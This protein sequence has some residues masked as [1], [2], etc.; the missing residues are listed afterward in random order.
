MRIVII[1]G[2][3][4][5]ALSV[6]EA[7]PSQSQVLVIGRK[8]GLEGD[9]ALSLEYQTIKKMG[10]SFKSITTGRLQRK[11]TKH[12]IFSLIKL[13]IGFFQ[14]L[15]ILKEF[16]PNVVLSFG[17]YVSIPVV[18]AS[19]F[20]RIP[21]VVHEQT[22]EAGLSN[23]FASLFAKKICIS[24]DSSKKFFPKSKIVLTGNP[25]RKFTISNIKFPI[26]NFKFQIDEKDKNLP[27]IY[28]TGGSSGSHAIN[29]LIEEII[30][31]LL[32]KNVVFHQTG[33]AQEFQDFS[34]LEDLRRS[35]AE[36]LERR[37][38]LTKFVEPSEVGP[39]IEKADIL[40]S[41]SGMNTVSELIQFQKPAL[42]I[43]LPYSQNKEQVKNAFFLKYLGLAEVADQNK[44]TAN[45][46]FD[47]LEIMLRNL[48]KYKNNSA[49]GLIKKD[50][51][52]KIVEVLGYSAE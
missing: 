9:K 10:I 21:I 14:A 34:R 46:L 11:F 31:K 16:K 17:G 1:G 19:F 48:D 4:S 28:I 41:R 3:F 7:L 47:L 22:L 5:P 32:E 2:H 26:S 40:I 23:K 44:L 49:K 36:K 38:F 35:F 24:W 43:P 52:K 45:D 25:I 42:L 12:T 30:E 18:L 51:A 15:K 6:I 33:D 37:Y 8:F 13:P 29:L 20:L 50:A 39:I 27:I